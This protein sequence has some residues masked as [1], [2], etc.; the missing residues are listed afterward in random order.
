MTA[1][2]ENGFGSTYN[3]LRAVWRVCGRGARG[4][5]KRAPLPRGYFAFWLPSLSAFTLSLVICEQ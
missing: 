5:S 4:P 2:R 1:K 3:G